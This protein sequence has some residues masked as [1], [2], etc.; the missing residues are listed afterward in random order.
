M[1]GQTAAPQPGPTHPSA[2]GHNQLVISDGVARGQG[3]GLARHV[4]GGD[5]AAS[6]VHDACGSSGSSQ[7]G[8]GS[9][10][11]RA[12]GRGCVAPRGSHSSQHTHLWPRTRMAPGARRPLQRRCG[13]RAGGQGLQQPGG[14][15]NR[16]GSGRVPTPTRP[17]RRGSRLRG[18]SRAAGPPPRPAHTHPQGTGRPCSVRGAR[19]PPPAGDGALEWCTRQ[20]ARECM[21]QILACSSPRMHSSPAPTPAF[22]MACA[23]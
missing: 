18:G 8:A 15:R 10:L 2:G 9:A 13:N 23:T 20:A 16:S 3:Q 22:I 19:R 7:T 17:S 5:L 12:A 6:A 14:G 4:R 1:P 21:P 11:G